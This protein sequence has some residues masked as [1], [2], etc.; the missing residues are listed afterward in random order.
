MLPKLSN[1]F[2]KRYWGGMLGT[3]T[4]DWRE[5]HVE[6]EPA[7]KTLERIRHV[8]SNGKQAHP[9]TPV[10]SDDLPELPGKLGVGKIWGSAR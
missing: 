10:D 7:T 1:A 9:E 3:L 6:V 5:K 2:A 4:E 8:R